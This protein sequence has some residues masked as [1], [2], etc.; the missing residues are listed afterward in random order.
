MTPYFSGGVVYEY[1]QEENDYGLVVLN[2]DGS[3]D[4]RSDYDDLQ[5]Q[6][7]TLDF[8]K[9][10]STSSLVPEVPFPKCN[11]KLITSKDFPKNFTAIP[12]P[13]DDGL[14]ELIVAG[15]KNPKQGKLVPVTD[16]NVKQT[17][18]NT[19]GTT[20]EGLKITV[21]G[22]DESNIPSGVTA[23]SG[24]GTTTSSPKASSSTAA[25]S[26]FTPV[27]NY[28]VVMSAILSALWLI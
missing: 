26:G 3:A 12:S 9:L 23:P 7:N 15:V 4:L 21:L 6:L 14:A 10:Q 11:A 28:G 2:E 24:T 17:V 18:K 13:P 1:A 27:A 25:A 8:K 19:D 5:K 16:L 22:E 20:I